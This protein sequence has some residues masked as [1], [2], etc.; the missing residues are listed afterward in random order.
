LENHNG[1]IKL[2]GGMQNGTLNVGGTLDASASKSGDGGFIETSAATV[3]FANDLQVTTLAPQGKTG[4]WLIDPADFT[5]D[6]L[7]ANAPGSS[8]KGTTLSTYLVTNNITIST[9]APGTDTTTQFFANPGHGDININSAV[10]WTASSTP[11]TLTLNAFNDVNVNAAI[12]AV[13]GNLVACCGRDVNV[14][15]AITTTDGSVLLSAGHDVKL[16][17]GSAMTT[18]RGNIELCA[19][20]DVIVGSKITLTNSGLASQIPGLTM[21]LGLVLS[22]GNS[23]TAP[24]V[25]GRVILPASGDALHPDVT[26]SAAPVTDVAIYYNPTSYTA[27]TDYSTNFTLVGGINFTQHM[28]VFPDVANKVYDGTT[29]A[30]LSGFKGSPVGVT[31]AGGTANFASAG[32]GN[33]KTVNY[34]GLSLDPTGAATYAFA[35]GCCTPAN[36]STTANI[37]PRPVTVKA[38]DASKIYGQTFTPANTAFTV[39]V[40]PLPGETITSVN[41]TTPGTP[42]SAA[43]A[44][45]PITPSGASGPNFN[46]ANYTITYVN[47]QLTVTKL[48]LTI[49]ADNA[50][51]T[52]G[53][54]VTLAPTAFSATGL[55]NGETVGSVTETSPGT[56]V[57]AS[58]AGSPYAITPSNASGGTFIPGNYT[59][60]YVNGILTV[61]PAPL[62]IT[63]SNVTKTYGQTPTLTGFTTSP[64]LNGETV[65]SVTETSP[66]T[67]AKAP[68]AGSPYVITPSDA[69]GGTFI[70]GNYS[71]SYVNGVLTVLPLAVTGSI[72]AADK[73]YDGNTSATI[74]GRTVTGVLG[75]DVVSYTGGTAT[76]DTPTPG[77]DKPVTGVGLGLSGPDAGNYTVNSTATTVA[78]ITK[79]VPVPPFMPPSTTPATPPVTWIPVVS[80][81]NAPPE[82]LT[83]APPPAPP[84]PYIVPAPTPVPVVVVP[85]PIMMPVT[86]PPEERYVPPLR[87]RK[88]D[89]N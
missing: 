25:G 71:I 75:G 67:P 51:K 12:T 77:T 80:P 54:T 86:P 34:S 84:A 82:L 37:T 2:M 66:G 49:T 62:I 39:P 30:T 29:T 24:G 15:A 55:V 33:G 41:M 73:T 38:D 43:V 59:I 78:D 52:Y 44:T 70:P 4:S 58:V 19:G 79:P 11:T 64:L 83:L 6:E 28:L 63:A 56:V 16:W 1:S 65:G 36:A 3:K 88:Q 89:R 61:T 40:P 10:S 18:T 47:G 81:P 74:T 7:L 23:A 69:T 48:L 60:R 45:Y 76:F 87:V 57:S 85:T 5:V 27:P 53:Q 26:R 20:N 32:V 21:D 42:A 50:A 35:T 8:L 72:T 14:R 31:L 68:V 9:M 46:P 13:N 22:A 17:A